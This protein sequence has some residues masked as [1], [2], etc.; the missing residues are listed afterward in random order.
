MSIGSSPAPLASHVA[1]SSGVI[2]IWHW[3]PDVAVIDDIRLIRIERIGEHTCRARRQRERIVV[4]LE[5]RETV[6]AAEPLALRFDI[7]R[8]DVDP[9][10][11]RDRR[12]P[13][14]RTERLGEQLAA[15]A[16]P[17][18]RNARSGRAAQQ[19]ANRSDP[20]LVVVDAHGPAHHRNAGEDARIGG[21]RGGRVERN[22][23]PGHA[24]AVEPLG[25]IR[26]TLGG[27]KAENRDGTH[28]S[29]TRGRRPILAVRPFARAPPLHLPEEMKELA[30]D[31]S[32]SGGSFSRTNCRSASSR[33][34][35]ATASRLTIVP[36]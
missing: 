35:P 20:R 23:G 17:E 14:R 22:E 26:R 11:L 27:R 16:M 18:D 10:D 1:T 29:S 3:K 9:A 33:C 19:V 4:P 21:H 13:H 28:E 32:L 12:P 30:R 6:A 31:G 7:G 24:A 36:R 34:T 2:S 25:E 8:L 5:R 15:Q